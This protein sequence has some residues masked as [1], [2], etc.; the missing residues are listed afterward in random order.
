MSMLEKFDCFPQK[1][2]TTKSMDTI[3]DICFKN[4]LNMN[5]ASRKF[6]INAETFQGVDKMK[7]LFLATPFLICACTIPSNEQPIVENDY[8]S[9]DIISNSDT[10]IEDSNTE[11]NIENTDSEEELKEDNSGITLESNIW[12]VTEAILIEDTCNWDTSLREFFGVGADAL[13]PND[14]TVDGFENSFEIEANDYGASGPISCVIN[15]LEFDCETQSVT[16][17]DFDLGTYGWTYAIDFSGF[18]NDERSLNGTAEVSFPTVTDW[19]IPIFQS[20]GIDAS[21][22]VQSFELS[23]SAN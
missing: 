7:T 18:I 4:F 10:S 3:C 19:L 13:L 21:Q 22:C 20:G 11:T 12:V 1:P 15:D 2:K 6:G 23:I 17:I 8:D 16:P 14:F 9:D 5:F